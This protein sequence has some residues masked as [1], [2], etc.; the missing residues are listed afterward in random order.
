[1]RSHT[2]AGGKARRAFHLEFP[3]KSGEFEKHSA[4]RADAEIQFR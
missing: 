1:M 3:A 4:A 2:G